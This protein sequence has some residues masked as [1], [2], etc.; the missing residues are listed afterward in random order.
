MDDYLGKL[1]GTGRVVVGGADIGSASY[2]IRVYRSVIIAPA[3]KNAT[4]PG[5]RFPGRLRARGWIEAEPA[6]IKQIFDAK[7]A[8]LKLRD[9]DSIKIG[10]HRWNGSR[11]ADITVLEGPVPGF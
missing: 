2:D 1:D 5:D 7:E 3:I 8:D 6:V 9:G 10:V 11:R 4:G